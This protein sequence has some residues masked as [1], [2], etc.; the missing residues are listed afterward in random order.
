MVVLWC[1]GS[2]VAAGVLYA[3]TVTV[4]KKVKKEEDTS[5]N[6]LIGSICMMFILMSIYAIL[7]R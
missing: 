3:N 4:L 1:Y 7:I 6:T 2:I 5:G